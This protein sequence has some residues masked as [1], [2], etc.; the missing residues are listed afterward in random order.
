MEPNIERWIDLD[1]AEFK[2]LEKP[3]FQ[4]K[5]VVTGVE[6]GFYQVDKAGYLW[7]KGKPVFLKVG[8]EFVGLRYAARAVN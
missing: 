2:S 4:R 8:S 6:A 1:S 5:I 7:C 3:I